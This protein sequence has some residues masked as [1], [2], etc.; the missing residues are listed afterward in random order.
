[1]VPRQAVLASIPLLHILR[2]LPSYFLNKD[3]Q[4]ID[5]N[6]LDRIAWKYT[7][8]RLSYRQFCRDMSTL[9][10]N[11]PDD[12]KLRD[13]TGGAV[14][15]A[16][17]FLRPFFHRVVQ[18]DF[19]KV[20]FYLR[21][22]A[23]SISR[24][25][26]E[27][28][29]GNYPEVKKIVD[30]M[31]LALGEELREKYAALHQEEISRLRLVINDLEQT[32]E[33]QDKR[34]LAIDDLEVD[35]DGDFE[36]EL[37][38]TDEPTLVTLDPLPKETT[39]PEPRPT[40]K[41]SIAI[42]PR[43]PVSFQ[44]PITPPESPRNSVLLPSVT[45]PLTDLVSTQF[46]FDSVNLKT[47]KPEELLLPLESSPSSEVPAS[48]PLT[49][50]RR[51]PVFSRSIENWLTIHA[52]SA[53]KIG[54]NL[55]WSG[56]QVEDPE[57]S[58]YLEKQ[59]E[60]T[61]SNDVG[62]PIHHGIDDW[63]DD[64]GDQ[65]DIGDDGPVSNFSS[66][67]SS[68]FSLETLY[69]NTDIPPKRLSFSHS[70]SNSFD[71]FASLSP[72]LLT[73]RTISF[74]EPLATTALEPTIDPLTISLPPS[75]APTTTSG[76]DLLPISRSVSPSAGSE[77]ISSPAPAQHDPSLTKRPSIITQKRRISLLCPFPRE[78]DEDGD[79]I[80]SS[81][82]TETASFIVT[83]FLVGAFITL[84]LFSTQR[85]TLLYVT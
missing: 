8:R 20:I 22:L 19:D 73:S 56:D 53:E 83:G 82:V 45:V 43:I 31:A 42:L 44:T 34:T 46:P 84:F 54:D 9:F 68:I 16:M 32:L 67:R 33:A 6:P 47:R 30:S 69:D 58:E 78:D 23:V 28:W 13:S 74:L 59:V 52:P 14:R 29:V 51:S 76:R 61:L 48:P 2:K 64:D 3:I 15:L 4:V 41:M 65:T 24:W 75:P 85:R 35:T 63:N 1:M 50:P 36:V 55:N 62:H 57:D 80:R 81:G 66:P 79:T 7:Q 27:A 40:L 77:S 38:E 39:P 37:G 71:V 18:D 21:T 60:Q 49:P 72:P 5:G 70:R 12:V 10:L 11:R 17:A 26:G 25:P